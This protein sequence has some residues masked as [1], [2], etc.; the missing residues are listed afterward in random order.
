VYSEVI[1][2]SILFVEVDLTCTQ[3]L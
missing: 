2:K 3:I 1:W